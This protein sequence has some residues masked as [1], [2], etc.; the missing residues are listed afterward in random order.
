MLYMSITYS[1]DWDQ[2]PIYHNII[3]CVTK[4]VALENTPE[5][6]LVIR[7]FMDIIQQEEPWYF[8]NIDVLVPWMQLIPPQGFQRRGERKK[9]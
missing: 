1:L 7:G 5:Y 2:S 8:M 6:I 3:I 9:R 4:N